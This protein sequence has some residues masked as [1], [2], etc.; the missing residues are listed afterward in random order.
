MSPPSLSPLQERENTV[1]RLE[2]LK[3]EIGA[4]NEELRTLKRENS[5]TRIVCVRTQWNLSNQG[6]PLGDRAKCPGNRGV[7]ISEVVLYSEATFGTPESV[8]II[9]VS[10]FQSVLIERGYT[11]LY[12][13]VFANYNTML[14]K[15]IMNALSFFIAS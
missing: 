7:L 2:K 14:Y 12:C 5:R 9:E 4:K 8:L 1:A 6:T 11:V 13:I 10:L 3:R 15:C